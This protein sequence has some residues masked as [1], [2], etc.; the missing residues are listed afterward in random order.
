[1]R[2]LLLAGLRV[3]S[4]E[5]RAVEALRYREVFSRCYI[6]MGEGAGSRKAQS[7]IP[8]V[9]LLPSPILPTP[10]SILTPGSSTLT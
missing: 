8:N 5:G 4:D 10:P 3:G 7:T 1:M 2:V 6:H 9:P